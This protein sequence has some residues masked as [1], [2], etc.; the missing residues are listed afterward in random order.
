MPPPRTRSSSSIPVLARG[1]G[2]ASPA[3]PTKATALPAM[4]REGLAPGAGPR[5]GVTA[6][7]TMVFHSP[8]ASQRPA[9]LPATAPQLWQTKREVDL[10]DVVRIRAV[11][12]GRGGLRVRD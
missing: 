11:R 6:S 10:A 3:R 9:Y 4:A 1:G 12:G 2:A 8:Q 5:R 7:S